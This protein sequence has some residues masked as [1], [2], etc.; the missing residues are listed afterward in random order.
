MG[1]QYRWI[2][3]LVVLLL[4]NGALVI[5]SIPRGVD[6][7]AEVYQQRLQVSP[8]QF[9]TFE[10]TAKRNHS[11]L[12]VE[13][14]RVSPLSSPSC[15]NLLFLNKTDYYN[16]LTDEAYTPIWSRLNEESNAYTAN[17]AGLHQIVQG[18]YQFVLEHVSG[19]EVI[20]VAIILMFG[21]SVEGIT[22]IRSTLSSTQY[23]SF[24]LP[25]LFVF[26][27]GLAL[28]LALSAIKRKQ[29]RQSSFKD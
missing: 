9:G 22:S 12:G 11:A 20:D 29:Y 16:Y 1:T 27:I 23:F 2:T 8:G 28:F 14:E 25:S 24:R 15:Y 7:D 26:G 10:C 21:Q 13:V 4:V 19:T 18:S 3:V 5:E 6:S 17:Y